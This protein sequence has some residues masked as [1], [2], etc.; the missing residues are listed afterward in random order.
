[1]FSQ[2]KYINRIQQDF[3]SIAW[4]MPYGWDLGVLGGG[5]GGGKKISM[6]HKEKSCLYVY[7]AIW[8]S[9]RLALVCL[10]ELRLMPENAI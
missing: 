7:C 5:G 3:R 10:F 4:V 9:G 1:M 8:L 2:I 6:F